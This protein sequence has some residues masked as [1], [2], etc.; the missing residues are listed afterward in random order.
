MKKT[1]GI[2]TVAVLFCFTGYTQDNDWTLD[3][4]KEGVE[5]Y[6][7]VQQ[8][9]EQEVVL[10]KVINTNEYQ[11]DIQWADELK[12]EGPPNTL[13]S[14]WK[15]DGSGVSTLELNAGETIEA[16]CDMESNKQLVIDPINMTSLRPTPIQKYIMVEVTISKK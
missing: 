8:C 1:I 5:V 15:D 11:I 3:L 6:Y 14:D 7:K 4:Q 2:L 12:V 13:R 9:N 10:L 16:T